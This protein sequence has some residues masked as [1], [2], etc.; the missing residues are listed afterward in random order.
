MQTAWKATG[1]AFQWTVDCDDFLSKVIDDTDGE[2]SQRAAALTREAVVL[3][4][5][6]VNTLTHR[7]TNLIFIVALE[8]YQCCTKTQSQI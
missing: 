5:S 4:H 3:L 2:R 8:A 7:V 6:I 1:H